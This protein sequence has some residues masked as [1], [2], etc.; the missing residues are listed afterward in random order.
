ME[1]DAGGKKKGK[2][3]R[4]KFGPKRG[5]KIRITGKIFCDRKWERSAV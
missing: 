3:R 4:G 5:G 2:I 1:S